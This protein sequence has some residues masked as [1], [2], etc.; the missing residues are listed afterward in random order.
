MCTIVQ[1]LRTISQIPN[2]QSLKADKKN[3]QNL[4]GF[5]YIKSF[6]Y[7]TNQD[8]AIEH[9]I[10]KNVRVVDHQNRSSFVGSKGYTDLFLAAQK[11]NQT[12]FANQ[13]SFPA[14]QNARVPELIP[15]QVQCQKTQEMPDIP[16]DQKIFER[17]GLFY[18]DEN[19]SKIS[20]LW[21]EGL[22]I[23]F[24]TQV[25]RGMSI[26]GRGVESILP[27]ESFAG[28]HYFPK[29]PDI[30]RSDLPIV[31]S[32]DPTSYWIGHATC[33]MSVPLR[34]NSGNRIAVNIITDPI[35][36]D[37]SS[38][39]YPR[40][41]KPGRMIEDCP[42]I[43]VVLI[44]HNHRDHYS[45]ETMQKMLLEQPALVVPVGD[46]EKFKKMGFT[47]VSE[48]N[49]W[50]QVPITVQRGNEKAEF[51]ITAVPSHH[52]SN[53]GINDLNR[54]SFVGYVIQGHEN[55]DIY[56]EGDSARLSS[57][58]IETLKNRFNIRSIFAPGGPD[59]VRKDMESTHQS[60]AD[61]L[62]MYFA[63]LI[64]KLY[65][66][67]GAH[68]SKTE[69]LEKASHRKMIYMHTK[70][71]K[72]GNLHFTDTEDSIE[73]IL[74]ALL[75]QDVHELKDYEKLVYNE[76]LEIA[77]TIQ[78]ENKGL[79]SQEIHD[80]IRAGVTVPKIGER[81]SLFD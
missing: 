25:E 28:Y 33:L 77:Q 78:F 47:N 52:W 59:E 45:E 7:G 37:L 22:R 26:L 39:A 5:E 32:S 68:L 15:L 76:L 62:K 30:Y 19:D 2:V 58:H 13:L 81:S 65:E 6:F 20:H 80:I 40:M 29:N 31:D 67:E 16:D 79:T 56:F 17:N 27:V 55:G 66:T 1:N 48:V 10:A 36:G 12:I 24:S 9:L 38:F 57:A 11:Y 3:I 73:R 74:K 35:E 60:S 50:Q 41:T 42:A 64:K 75:T 34:T 18:Y 43:H 44:S 53:R 8:K 69:F 14:V 4:R 49:W 21:D 54:S 46:G 51:T 72:L 70:T 63:V 71:Y 61:G 23:L